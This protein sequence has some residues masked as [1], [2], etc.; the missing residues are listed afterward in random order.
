MHKFEYLL[1]C[2]KNNIVYSINIDLTFWK[3]FYLLQ[4]PNKY[5]YIYRL[6]IYITHCASNSNKENK[7]KFEYGNSKRYIVKFNFQY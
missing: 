6:A 1:G 3:T 7:L 2:C 4:H 5:I